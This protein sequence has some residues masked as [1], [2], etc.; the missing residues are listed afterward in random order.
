M[1]YDKEFIKNTKFLWRKLGG[2]V[3][4]CQSGTVPV[5][6]SLATGLQWGKEIFAI[7]KQFLEVTEVQKLNNFMRY[8]IAVATIMHTATELTAY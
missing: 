6:S 7:N 8:L 3:G 5:A 2:V 4:Q 1:A